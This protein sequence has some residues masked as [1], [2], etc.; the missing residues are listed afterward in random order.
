MPGS[1]QA[2]ILLGEDYPSSLNMSGLTDLRGVRAVKKKFFFFLGNFLSNWWLT[3]LRQF[4]CFPHLPAEA[5]EFG[6]PL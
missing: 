6:T 5:R 1:Y 3:N 2:Y 4:Q